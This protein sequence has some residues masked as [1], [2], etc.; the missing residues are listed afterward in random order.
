MSHE[1]PPSDSAPPYVQ[2]VHLAPGGQAVI[3]GALVCAREAC[4]LEVGSGAFVLTGPALGPARDSLCNPRD[5]LYFSLLDCGADEDRFA[6]ERFRLFELIG[7]VLGQDR[8]HETQR[9]CGQCAAALMA[10][11]VKAAVESAARM[12]S[13]TLDYDRPRTRV[14]NAARRAPA[15]R[16]G[17]R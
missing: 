8:G 12:A 9:E 6:A 13:A 10:G 7:G 2:T 15:K 16:E 5:E 3:N 4:T 11:D 17:T 1:P 14:S